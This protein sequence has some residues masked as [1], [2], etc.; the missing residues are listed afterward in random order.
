M[1]LGVVVADDDPAVLAALAAVFESHPAFRLL[2]QARS[3]TAA[4]QAARE[5]QADVVV[6]DARMPGGGVPAV[7]QLRAACPAAAIVVVSAHAD[8]RLVADMLQ[9]G[10]AGVLAK[11]R[12]GR[13]LPD[14]VRRCAEGEVVLATPAAPDGLRLL[15]DRARRAAD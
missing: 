12:I 4:V 11:G 3:G 14:L 9:A 2:A 1:S 8:A 6:L 7:E 5:Q 13:S 15:V 10:A